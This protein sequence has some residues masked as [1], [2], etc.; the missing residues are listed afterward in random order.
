MS[1]N[2]SSDL[3]AIDKTNSDRIEIFKAEMMLEKNLMNFASLLK[4]GSDFAADVG[5]CSALRSGAALIFPRQRSVFVYR[6]LTKVPTLLQKECVGLLLE[7]IMGPLRNQSC[8][9]STMVRNLCD[10][11]DQAMKISPVDYPDYEVGPIR[12]LAYW[13]VV[14]EVSM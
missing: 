2:P 4:L 1:T 9:D 11:I 10:L 7:S 8:S 3:L 5:D 14:G 12:K 6:R 13:Y